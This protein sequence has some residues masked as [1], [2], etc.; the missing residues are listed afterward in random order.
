MALVTI[1]FDG[2]VYEAGWATT[3]A[4]AAQAG[5]KHAVTSGFNATVGTGTR[6]ISVSAGE[7]FLGGITAYETVST[8]ITLA[9]N[10]GNA[11]RLDRIIMRADWSNNSVTIV[12]VPV[13]QALVQVPGSK[14]E[15]PL[16][17]IKVRPNVSVIDAADIA[18]EKPLIRQV[19]VFNTNVSTADI[20]FENTGHTVATI[21]RDDP[22]WPYK[23]IVYAAARFDASNGFA[24][25]QA[26]VNAGIVGQTLS[27]RL[28]LGGNMP[29]VLGGAGSGVLL[30]PLEASMVILP[31][32]MTTGNRLKLIQS[33]MNHFTV[34]QIPA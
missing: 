33:S 15:M 13:A 30:G 26:V 19:R 23:V 28:D 32:G 21:T 24:Q 14:W 4:V 7:A 10:T 3:L 17:Q 6:A 11:N 29:A 1:G 27:P 2:S 25:V 31:T 34:H 18:T 8:P 5:N 22:G 16:A 20:N 12:V 9:A